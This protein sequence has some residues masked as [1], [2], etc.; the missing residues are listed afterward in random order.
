MNAI[1]RG[2]ILARNGG[3]TV[4]FG[5]ADIPR[6]PPLHTMQLGHN[7]TVISAGSSTLHTNGLESALQKVRESLLL[8]GSSTAC[9]RP[10]SGRACFSKGAETLT[11]G[12]E[13]CYDF[14][15]EMQD[16]IA[17]WEEHVHQLIRD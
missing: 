3:G 12:L 6:V 9:H 4:P 8:D 2:S 17:R 14:Y 15:P 5:D 10:D 13:Q 1:I 7:Q 11:G 16:A